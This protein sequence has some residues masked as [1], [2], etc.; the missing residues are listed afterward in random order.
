MLKY[1][2]IGTHTARRTFVCLSIQK[3]MPADV[4]MSITGHKTYRMM[5]KYLKIADT[6]K[7]HQ[8]DKVWGS[9]ITNLK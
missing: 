3:G 5:Q 7:R 8:M 6:H 9:S 1:E 4:V 2:L